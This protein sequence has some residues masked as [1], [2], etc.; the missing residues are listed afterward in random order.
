MKPTV[1]TVCRPKTEWALARRYRR[2]LADGGPL[3][4]IAATGLTA[5]ATFLILHPGTPYRQKLTMARALWRQY[6][7][8]HP[9][10]PPAGPIAIATIQATVLTG[11]APPAVRV[12]AAALAFQIERHHFRKLLADT[13]AENRSEM[14]LAKN[15]RVAAV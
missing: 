14:G 4:P 7:L 15:G 9:Q 3:P 5:L 10:A 8:G 12:E 11:T 2:R 6:R 1:K 13:M